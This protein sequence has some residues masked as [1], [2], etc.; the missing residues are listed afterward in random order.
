MVAHLNVELHDGCGEPRIHKVPDRHPQDWILP[1]D[2]P[3]QGGAAGRAEVIDD[4]VPIDITDTVDLQ[5]VADLCLA[6]H[7]KLLV[8]AKTAPT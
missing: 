6:L 7:L 3:V 5:T 8:R 1:F 2:Y 4:C